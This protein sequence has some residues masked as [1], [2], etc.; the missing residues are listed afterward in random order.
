MFAGRLFLTQAS[1]VDDSFYSG[2]DTG[3]EKIPGAQAI[4]FLEIPLGTHGMDEIIS[5]IDAFESVVE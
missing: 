4:E 1:Q 5:D 2:S 3:L